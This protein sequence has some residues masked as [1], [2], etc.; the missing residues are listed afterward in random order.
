MRFESQTRILSRVFLSLQM[1][2]FGH[3]DRN[4]LR[5]VRPGLQPNPGCERGEADA[6]GFGGA[7]LGH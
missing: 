6:E 3:G 7:A 2:L 4:V 5:E 1:Q